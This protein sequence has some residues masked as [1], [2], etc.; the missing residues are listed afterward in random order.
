MKF[1]I[2]RVIGLLAVTLSSAAAAASLDTL[3]VQEQEKGI[4]ERSEFSIS[5]PYDLLK[6]SRFSIIY[7]SGNNGIFNLM[8]HPVYNSYVE[9]L[10]INPTGA[11]IAILPKN[12]RDLSIISNRIENLTLANIKGERKTVP[13]TS[14]KEKKEVPAIT[15]VTYTSDAREVLTANSLGEIS[16]YSTDGYHLMSVIN[17]GK[18]Y[19]LIA[20]SPNKYFI[21]ASHGS[22]MDIW[23]VETADLKRIVRFAG[24]I[25]HITFSPDSREIAV[26]CDTAGLHIV[27]SIDH[28]RNTV[29]RGVLDVRCASFHPEGKYLAYARK[30]SVIVYNLINRS[31]VCRLGSA[32]GS[33]LSNIITLNFHANNGV[34]TLSHNSG[35]KVIFW[36]MTSLPPL[37]KSQLSEEVDKLMT[38]WI[39]QMDGESME[40]YR[41]RVTDDN[42]ARQKAMLLDQAAT[43]IA[44]QTIKLENPFI[45]EEYDSENHAIDIKFNELN[46][47]K[48]EIPEDEFNEVRNGNLSYENP[49]YTLDEN[50]EFQLVYLEVV[51]E[52]TDKIYIFDKRSYIIEDVAFED[53]GLD[54]IPVAMLQTVNMEMEALQEQTRQIMEERKQE[55]VI[56]DKTEI[57]INSEIQSD[58]DAEGNKIYNYNLNYQYDV[59]EGFSYQEDFGPGKFMVNES[60]AALT[61]LEAIRTAL[62]GDMKKYLDEAKAI[63]IT[64][65]GTADAIPVGRIPYDGACGEFNETPYYAKDELSS[66]TVTAETDIRNNEQLAFIRAA[67]VKTWLEDKVEEL[68]TYKDKCI[69]NY[70]TEVSDVRGGEFRRIIVEIKF[71]DIF[72]E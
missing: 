15:A 10:Y 30:D 62:G 56:T 57:T 33:P 46:T 40:E 32:F 7:R 3:G 67:S 63:D 19:D 11:S 70:R 50:D 38:D 41:V 23:N 59:S 51:N 48:L 37:Y 43:A 26:S 20:I 47:I 61:M 31:V 8:N 44:T 58:F 2:A 18:T 13:G 72:N 21:A 4:R 28:R 24:R 54:F 12:R 14:G 5:K 29:T 27:N 16:T 49:V 42:A 71:R 25:N 64:I 6:I 66:M 36:D 17:T 69:Y 68:K 35:N 34:V 60:N 65:T 1:R 39:R 52:A 9:D 22:E 53:E 45:G 55:N